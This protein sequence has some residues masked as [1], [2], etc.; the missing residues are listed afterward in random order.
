VRTRQDSETSEIRDP[1]FKNIYI[2]SL[3]ALPARI[4]MTIGA[5][6]EDFESS[7]IEDDQLGPKFGLTWNALDNITLRAAYFKSLA[8]PLHFEQSIEQTQVAGFNQRYDD[9]EGSE[10]KQ[11]GFGVDAKLAYGIST[12]AQYARRELLA[13]L[14]TGSLVSHEERDEKHLRGYLYWA[15]TDNLG[16]RLGYEREDVDLPLFSPQALTI[17]KTVGFSYHWPFGLLLDIEGTRISQE[18]SD[19]GITDQDDFWNVDAVIGYRLP[20]RYGK[21]EIVAKNIL[22]KEFKYYDMS[23]HT[24]EN[25]LPQFQPERQLFVRFTLNF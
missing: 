3:L 12:G 5:T 18:M 19:F 13:P 17:R 21:V 23:F 20:K 2:Y 11:F 7:V 8:R 15:A 1:R 25:L 24:D 9:V 14:P 22:D 4:N 16:L 10:I 6:F